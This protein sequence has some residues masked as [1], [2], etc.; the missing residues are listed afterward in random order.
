[1]PRLRLVQMSCSHFDLLRA[2][3]APRLA[4]IIISCLEGRSP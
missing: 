1:M 2:P 3:N 4:E